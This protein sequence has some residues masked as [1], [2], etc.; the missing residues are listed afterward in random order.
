MVGEEVPVTAVVI[1][2]DP[3]YQ[4]QLSVKAEYLEGGGHSELQIFTSLASDRQPLQ[5][6][7]LRA[8]AWCD[9][10]CCLGQLV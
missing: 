3:L 7:H 2:S 8:H 4:V 1:A 5:V 9:I 10:P 6:C